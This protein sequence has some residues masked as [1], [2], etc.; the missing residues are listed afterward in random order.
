LI[1]AAGCGN[2]SFTLTNTLRERG[3]H[4]KKVSVRAAPTGIDRTKNGPAV[5][6]ARVRPDVGTV[7]ECLTR[8]FR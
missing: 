8:I 3:V 1:A 5:N 6:G 4:K 7:K 2:M